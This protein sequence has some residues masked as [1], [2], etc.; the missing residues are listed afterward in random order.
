MKGSASAPASSGNLGPGFDALALA[1]E[2]RCSVVVE[3]S[4]GWRITEMGDA[5]E[6]EPDDFVRRAISSMVDGSFAVEISNPIPRSRGLGSS[7]AVA[8]ASGAAALRSLG[9][10]PTSRFLFDSVSKLEGHSDN[11]AAAVYGGLVAAGDGV[12]RHLDL[13]PD[14]RIVVAVPDAPL[15]TSTARAVLSPDIDRAAATRNLARVVFLVDGLRTGD[16][17]ALGGAGGDEL[18]EKARG[19]LSPITGELMNAARRAGALHAAWSGAGPSAIA[20]VPAAAYEAVVDALAAVLD[21]AGEVRRLD[22]A[23][24]GWR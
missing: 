22:V 13:H 5:Y 9:E 18:H 23:T 3:R 14:L 7:S 20:F 6:P 19:A 8:V 24:D 2:L 17:I 15:A 16:P 11:A 12:V 4:D 10:E 1:L 21:G